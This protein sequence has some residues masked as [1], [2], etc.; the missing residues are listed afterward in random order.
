[1]HESKLAYPIGVEIED[2]ADGDWFL[3]YHA[4]EGFQPLTYAIRTS[5]ASAAEEVWC[6]QPRNAGTTDLGWLVVLPLKRSTVWRDLETGRFVSKN[7]AYLDPLQRDEP[8]E[9][10]IMTET[11]AY[12][13]VGRG[14]SSIHFDTSEEASTSSHHLDTHWREPQ[15]LID[16]AAERGYVWA[17]DAPLIDSQTVPDEEVVRFAVRGPIP[18][19]G[20]P[21]GHVKR[22]FGEAEPVAINLDDPLAGIGSLDQVAIDLYVLIAAAFGATI[23]YPGRE[24]GSDA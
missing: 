12:A 18:H 23:T 10:G 5:D 16:E 21:A 15:R 4:G 20:V 13:T 14:G 3:V 2:L 22:F 17:P 9:R 24:V 11:I 7:T 6:E 1:M 8:F 19:E